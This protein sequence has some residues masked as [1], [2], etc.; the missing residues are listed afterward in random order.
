[1]CARSGEGVLKWR[2]AIVAARCVD[3]PIRLEH[4]T[5]PDDA[6]RRDES[7]YSSA[8]PCCEG[9]PPAPAGRHRDSTPSAA[10]AG[11]PPIPPVSLVTRAPRWREAA[12]RA[13]RSSG[14]GVCRRPGSDEALSPM[15]RVGPR[16]KC[17]GVRPHPAVLRRTRVHAPRIEPFTKRMLLRS[18]ES[19]PSEPLAGCADS[20][21]CVLN[22]ARERTAP[23][24]RPVSGVPAPAQPQRPCS[25]GSPVHVR[26]CRRTGLQPHRLNPTASH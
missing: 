22:V 11:P 3:A 19:R 23:S 20:S 7:A 6:R 12:V 8:Q 13:R 24:G 10:S 2:R 9:R 18:R 5:N 21:G 14:R 4:W 16:G 25:A 26:L 1:M 17:T 15:F